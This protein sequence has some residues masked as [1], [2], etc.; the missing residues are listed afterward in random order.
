[1]IGVD[2][3]KDIAVLKVDDIVGTLRPI[4]VGTSTGLRVGQGSLAIGNPFGLDHTLTT[5]VISGIGREVNSPA[6]R[7]ISNVIQTDAAINPGNSGEYPLCT[8][9][10]G[11]RRISFPLLTHLY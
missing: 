4:D 3:T 10:C 1:V 5:G 2:P 7:P 6:G 9:L 11:G 8:I